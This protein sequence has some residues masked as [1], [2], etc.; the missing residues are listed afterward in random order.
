MT[1]DLNPMGGWPPTDTRPV[2]PPENVPPFCANLKQLLTAK[3][4][5]MS[6][7]NAWPRQVSFVN[8]MWQKCFSGSKKRKKGTV[9][10]LAANDRS[11]RSANRLGDPAGT[12]TPDLRL[13]SSKTGVF[14]RFIKSFKVLRHNGFHLLAVLYRGVK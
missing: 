8:S 11:R 5:L 12:R 2:S 7:T 4:R 6:Q 10:R 13:K 9:I 14:H 1:P 3:I